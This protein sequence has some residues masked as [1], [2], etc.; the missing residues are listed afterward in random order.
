MGRGTKGE[1][2]PAAAPTPPTQEA[3]KKEP[4]TPPPPTPAVVD[5]PK[6][7]PPK[8]AVA[9]KTQGSGEG[10]VCWG[11]G[12]VQPP[13]PAPPFKTCAR[14]REDGVE[15]LPFCSQE[16]LK[17][18]WPRLKAWLAE[19]KSS[20]GGLAETDG[21]NAKEKA[22]INTLKGVLKEQPASETK[23]YMGLLMQADELKLKGCYSKAEDLLKEAVG[24]N[25]T[26]PVGYAALGEIRALL[27]KP[28][29]AAKLYAKAMSLFP[30]KTEVGSSYLR[31]ILA[32]HR[33]PPRR[34]HLSW[35]APRLT[36]APPPI[37][38]RPRRATTRTARS[39]GPPPRSPL[40]FGST[41]HRR[42]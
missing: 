5:A 9:E 33:S 18:N 24:L 15:P 35:D 23:S 38:A 10:C 16:C 28:A 37:F 32:L 19:R 41:C 30:K 39:Y 26:S 29:E 6:A 4:P 14:C 22:V 34:L 11:C 2:K 7:E 12:A 8:A 25:P 21:S 3:P 36:A 17:A 20:G 1:A 40:S 42:K 31:L 13:P 27:N